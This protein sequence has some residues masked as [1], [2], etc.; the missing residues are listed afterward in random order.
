MSPYTFTGKKWTVKAAWSPKRE[1][2]PTHPTSDLVTQDNG[3]GYPIGRDSGEQWI[4]ELLA[5]RQT[6][7][8][9]DM[10]TE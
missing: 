3:P 2:Y 7:G 8:M 4:K 5:E 6:P 10:W 9:P 1:Y